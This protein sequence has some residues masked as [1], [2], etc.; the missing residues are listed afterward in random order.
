MF[1]QVVFFYRETFF[2]VS[3]TKIKIQIDLNFYFVSETI[4]LEKM[5][6]K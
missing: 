6:A 3:A 2:F 5:N 1:P 4:F